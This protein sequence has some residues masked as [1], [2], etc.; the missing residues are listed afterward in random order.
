MTKLMNVKKNKKKGFTLVELI[1]V[2][3]IIAI[4]AALLIP[5]MI[6]YID[7]ARNQTAVAQARSIYV[8]AEYVLTKAYG[9]DDPAFAGVDSDGDGTVTRNAEIEDYA[10]IPEITGGTPTFTY[11]VVIADW[12]VQSVVYKTDKAEVTFTPGEG[13]D[14]VKL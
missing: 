11:S 1:V 2:M 4:L 12:H 10:Q 13:A 8:A 5:S 9:Y 7:D 6:R 14:I 3:I